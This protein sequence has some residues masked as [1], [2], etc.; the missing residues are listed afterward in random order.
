MGLDEVHRLHWV[1]M[2]D[3]DAANVRF[4]WK[5]DLSTFTLDRCSQ[6]GDNAQTGPFSPRLQ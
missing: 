4:G 3:P 6:G 5:T 2:R 1:F